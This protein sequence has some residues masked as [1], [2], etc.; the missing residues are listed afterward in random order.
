M[1]RNKEKRYFNMIE[2]LLA[3]TVIA[4]GMTSILGL[5]PVGLNASRDA[6]AENCSADVIDQLITYFRVINESGSKY[7]ENFGSSGNYSDSNNIDA[8]TIDSESAEFLTAYNGAT[9]LDTAG[10]FPRVA[11][12]WAIFHAK[13]SALKNRVFFVVQGPNCTGTAGVH[14]IDYS[15]MAIVWK[16][17]ITINTL[18]NEGD[19]S[20]G[21]NV[22]PTT[23][24]YTYF[25][26]LNIEL[27]WPLNL[28][29][30]ERK[31]HYYQIVIVKPAF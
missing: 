29:Y 3:L 23:A 21:T 11:E 13:T 16:S 2:I 26:R 24:D 31:K 4:I 14:P 6:V 12:G 18:A 5:F 7:S 20:W 10:T 1:L 22:W 30:A 8:A 27:S 9:P 17:T 19:T 28:P 25:A 15:A